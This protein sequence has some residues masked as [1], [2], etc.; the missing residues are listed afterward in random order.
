MLVDDHP[1][2]RSGLRGLLETDAGF[3]IVAEAGEGNAALRYASH[4]HIDV[5]LMDIE[6]SSGADGVDI[7]AQ[8]NTFSP[9]PD[10]LMMSM[11]D[12]PEYVER[13]KQAGARGYV[14]KT[15]PAE[16]ILYA[17]DEVVAG[18]CY[19]PLMRVD[20]MHRKLPTRRQMQ[21]LKYIAQGMT[22]RQIARQLGM[23]ERTVEAH[24]LN[25]RFEYNINTQADLI[26]FAVDCMKL[27]GI[28]DDGLEDG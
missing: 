24:R 5:V 13:A 25:I 14:V 27:Y 3:Q 1:T 11:H 15:A 7:T 10:V 12:S 18:R 23:K 4:M 8:L 28:P 17:I 16:K 19:W 21:V 22:S 20:P 2:Y 9:K 6:L 26:L